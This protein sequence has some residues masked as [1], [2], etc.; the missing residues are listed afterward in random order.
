MTKIIINFIF[1][2]A[3]MIA[4]VSDG[5]AAKSSAQ[6][7]YNCTINSRPCEITYTTS[8]DPTAMR[9][10]NDGWIIFT[11]TGGTNEGGYYASL[12]NVIIYPDPNDR[13]TGG[14]HCTASNISVSR[15]IDD[16]GAVQSPKF[17][18]SN[19][20]G[21]GGLNCLVENNS[22]SNTVLHIN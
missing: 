8:S 11:L 12:S 13:S 10:S 17:I 15:W 18:F 2:L 9:F 19:L 6:M 22:S 3:S 14:K 16:R 21:H 4:V 7:P 5:F 20:Q 1:I